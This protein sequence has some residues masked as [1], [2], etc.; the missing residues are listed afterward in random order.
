[1]RDHNLTAQK[2]LFAASKLGDSTA[3]FLLIKEAV[4]SD[5]LA[6][7][8]LAG[9]RRHLKTLADDYNLTAMYL[10]GQIHELEGKFSHA[11]KIYE[12]ATTSQGKASYEEKASDSTLGDI[13]KAVSRLRAK[14]GDK[15]GAQ[16]AIRRC[17]L[18]YDDPMAYYELAKVYTLPL[19]EDF[20]NYM[21]KAAASGEPRAAHEL[22]V[23]YYKQSQRTSLGNPNDR[24][25]VP[26]LS[27]RASVKSI[28]A[29]D[30]LTIGAESDMPISQVYLAVLLRA[31][32]KPEEGLEW[33]GRAS[34]STQW[35]TAISWLRSRWDQRDSIDIDNAWDGT[36]AV[37]KTIVASSGK[38]IAIEE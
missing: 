12:Q 23:L 9:P 25:T 16:E 10:A 26:T 19:T 18:Q 37:R 2:L 6:S 38:T 14:A 35:T 29:R 32:G 30:W 27:N 17:A 4:R 33:L 20:E 24:S 34:N 1:M 22:G 11:L 21:L 5:K 31:A 8:N 28:L 13:W 7:P 3:T 36:S 15:T